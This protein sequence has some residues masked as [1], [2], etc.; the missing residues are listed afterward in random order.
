[1]WVKKA[2]RVYSSTG[3]RTHVPDIVLCCYSEGEVGMGI[4]LSF[5]EGFLNGRLEEVEVIEIDLM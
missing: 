1:M 3:S 4:L 2:Q 5:L